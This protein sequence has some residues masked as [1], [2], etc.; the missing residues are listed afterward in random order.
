MSWS[1]CYT[2]YH[3]KNAPISSSTFMANNVEES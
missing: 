1:S 2:R 3:D